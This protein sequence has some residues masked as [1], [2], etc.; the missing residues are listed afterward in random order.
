MKKVSF[1]I[2]ICDH[3]GHSIAVEAD[4]ERNLSQDVIR[5]PEHKCEAELSFDCKLDP[6]LFKSALHRQANARGIYQL[7][8]KIAD[9][10]QFQCFDENGLVPCKAPCAREMERF[11]QLFQELRNLLIVV[12]DESQKTE[13]M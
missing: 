6:D 13:G 8:E 11:F 3:N 9:N 7:V 2:Y 12:S 4:P 1:N 10:S 5:C